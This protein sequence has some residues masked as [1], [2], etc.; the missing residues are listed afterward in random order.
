[1]QNLQIEISKEKTMSDNSSSVRVHFPWYIVEVI[2]GVNLDSVVRNGAAEIGVE[3]KMQGKY[4]NICRILEC[5]TSYSCKP[6]DTLLASTGDLVGVWATAIETFQMLSYGEVTMIRNADI[7]MTVIGNSP[8]YKEI[9]A[10]H[11]GTA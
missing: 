11:D 3:N 5:P 9:M 6:S 10:K 2:E 8:L 1:M 7:F 4:M